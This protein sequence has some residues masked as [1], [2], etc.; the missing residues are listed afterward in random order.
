[1]GD[2]VTRK[3]AFDVNSICRSYPNL[4]ALLGPN[5]A[6]AW[7]AVF[8]LR[9]DAMHRVI[10]DIIKQEY[11]RPGRVGQRP[12][13]REEEVDVETLLYGETNERPITDALPELMG[14]TGMTIRDF[15]KKVHMS[16]TQVHRTVKGTYAPDADQLRR[17]ARAVGKSPVYFPEYRKMM[18]V[19]AFVRLIEEHPEIA[20][21]IFA[22]FVQ[23]VQAPTRGGVAVGVA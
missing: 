9:P 2:D 10:A 3:N 18:A 8:R 12:M 14:T 22:R 11:A 13:P 19:A 23:V 7:D 16:S 21:T 17:M 5:A 4:Q 20:T 1:M 15:A 6:K